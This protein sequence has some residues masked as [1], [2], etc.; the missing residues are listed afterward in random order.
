[1]VWTAAGQNG[2]TYAVPVT[3][4][5]VRGQDKDGK[6][7]VTP[8]VGTLKSALV[9]EGDEQTTTMV[10]PENGVWSWNVN[11]ATTQ[12]G[13]MVVNMNAYAYDYTL[14]DNN[15]PLN[16]ERLAANADGTGAVNFVAGNV[17]N[18]DIDFLEE[19]ITDDDKLC[20]KVTVTIDS[21]KVKTVYPVFK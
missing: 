5:I 17:Y 4:T 8:I 16:I 13:S 1:M 2:K 11:P 15:T 3:K 14:K 18:M 9:G 20:V 21:W 7:I 10:K 12:F 6:D 19:N